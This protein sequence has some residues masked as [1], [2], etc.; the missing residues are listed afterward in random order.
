MTRAIFGGWPAYRESVVDVV[1]GGA[2]VTLGPEGVIAGEAWTPDRPV[3]IVTAY[4]PGVTKEPV[5]NQAAQSRLLELLE[6]RGIAWLPATGRSRDAAWQEPS[7]AVLEVS[8][9]EAIKIAR[10]FAQDAIFCWDGQRLRVLDC[11]SGK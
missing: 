7:V 6:D 4:N 1:V 3:Y 5:A 8:E 11:A 10:R 9:V 2:L